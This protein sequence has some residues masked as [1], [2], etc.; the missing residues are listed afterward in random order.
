MTEQLSFALKTES[1]LGVAASGPISDRREVS[2][3]VR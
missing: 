2:G 1:Y 3:F